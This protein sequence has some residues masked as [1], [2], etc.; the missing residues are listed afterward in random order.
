[1]KHC[2][3]DTETLG[4]T[5]GSIV[6]SIGACMFKPV[7]TTDFMD[8]R[9]IGPTFYAN[10]SRESCEAAGLTADPNTVAWWERQSQEARDALEV[11][12]V[13]LRE[14]LWNLSAW[15]QREGAEF[16]WSNGANFD[17]PILEACYRAVGMQAPWSYWSSRCV[18]TLLDMGQVSHKAFQRIGTHHDALADAIHQARCCAIASGRL[19]P[20]PTPLP[21]QIDLERALS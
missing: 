14:A 1:M 10:V 9:I 4:A 5:P 17:Q 7:S 18:R 16:V 13:D 11:D 3:I 21:E 6:R 8:E 2:M 19:F 20:M 12:K 15:W